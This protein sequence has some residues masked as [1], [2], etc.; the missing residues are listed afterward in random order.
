METGWA[1]C[2]L[3]L[4]AGAGSTGPVSR[5]SQD[6]WLHEGSR[7]TLRCK[8]QCAAFLTRLQLLEPR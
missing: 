6:G 8:W 5:N 1:T 2:A 7:R 4:G 3:S